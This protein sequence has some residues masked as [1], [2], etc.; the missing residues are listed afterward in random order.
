VTEAVGALDGLRVVDAATLIAGPLLAS[1]LG[2]HGADVVKVE[3][4]RGDAL[5]TLGEEREGVGLWWA[6]VGRNK[7]SVTLN[8]SD[9]RGQELLRGLLD[10]AD[11][12]I[13]GFRPG[14]LERWGLGPD[15]LHERNPRLVVVR[16]TGFGQDGPRRDLPG[17]GTLAEAYSGYAHLTGEPD[18]PPT[19][20]GF[21]LGDSVAAL[22]GA[23]G[24]LA[25][26]RH[27]DATGRGQT[28]DLSLYEPLHWLL[29][30]QSTV[31]D[32]TGTVPGRTGNRIHFTAPRNAYQ[33]ADGRWVAVTASSQSVADRIMHVVGR[34]DIVEEPWYRS[35]RGRAAHVDELDGIV[36]G[37]IA[38]RPRDEVL[39]AFDAGGAPC[40][41]VLAA[42]DI[43]A[44]P[45][46][47][48]RGTITRAH[49]PV[50]GD[51]AMPAPIPR[52]DATPGSIRTPAPSLGEHTREVLG[53]GAGEYAALL[54]DGVV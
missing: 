49:H 31:Y 1:L 52:L 32:Q 16:V 14:T 24:V 6:V 47:A 3:H 30:A 23:V 19:L 46:Y 37:W 22:A 27:R 5:R 10:G 42:D 34:P 20:P 39:R 17:F 28:I 54:A 45:H 29:G 9:E 36:G 8:L 21:A 51:V 26:L 40:A 43:A 12:L 44:D 41:P 18:G 13:E 53:L 48:A 35:A 50:L 11:V 38:G 25:A 33:A 4:P 15:V 7:R 2:D